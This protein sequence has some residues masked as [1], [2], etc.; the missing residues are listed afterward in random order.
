VVVPTVQLP[1][2]P[3]A[4]LV[5]SALCVGDTKM[6]YPSLPLTA[7][8]VKVGVRATPVVPLTGVVSVGA[9]SVPPVVVKLETVDQAPCPL[10]EEGSTACTC[11]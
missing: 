4:G 6:R 3:T 5:G 1:Q 7:V 9:G 11:Q 2:V 10:L 8:Q